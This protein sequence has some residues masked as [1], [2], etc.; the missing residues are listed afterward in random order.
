MIPRIGPTELII[1]LGIACVL[2]PAGVIGLVVALVRR[3]KQ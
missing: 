2:I 3:K 1:I